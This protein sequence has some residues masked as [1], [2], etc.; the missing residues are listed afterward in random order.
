MRASWSETT[1]TM[2]EKALKKSMVR[3]NSFLVKL[4]QIDKN[5]LKK[6]IQK[7]PGPKNHKNNFNILKIKANITKNSFYIFTNRGEIG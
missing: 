4:Y 5:T 3:R 7:N 6:I 1:I 2:G